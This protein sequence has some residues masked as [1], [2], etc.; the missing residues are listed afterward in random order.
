VKPGNFSIFG[1]DN[2][3]MR[4]YLSVLTSNDIFPD[5]IILIEQPE[6]KITQQRNVNEYFDNVSTVV[7]VAIQNN[8]D[9]IKIETDD[10]NAKIVEK[11]IKSISSECIIYSGYAGAILG[12]ELLNLGKSFIHIHPGKLPEYRG[13]TTMYYSILNERKITVTAI[14]LKEEIDSGPVIAEK[15]FELPKE[16]DLIDSVFDPYFRSLLL[17][18]IL[19]KHTKLQESISSNKVNEEYPPYFIIH[20]VLKHI[21]ILSGKNNS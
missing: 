5:S 15:S 10:I 20:P 4:A 14:F 3:R 13:S 1:A 11:T 17:L 12:K 18:E 6:L 8:I 16:I 2:T 21:A 19:E 7:D 9:L